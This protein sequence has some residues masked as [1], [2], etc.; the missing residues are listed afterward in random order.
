M[1]M[2]VGVLGVMALVLGGAGA[3]SAAD[4]CF[5]D[6]VGRVIVG[7]SFSLP[8]AGKCKQFG[9][10]MIIPIGVI[11]GLACGTSNGAEIRFNLSSSHFA[12]STLVINLDRVERSGDASYCMPDVGLFGSVGSCF[13]TTMEQIDCPANRPI[14]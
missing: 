11:H 12:A 6:G 9:G 14:L 8:A 13:G 7:K 3:A 10:Y 4:M 1:R 2:L 5:R